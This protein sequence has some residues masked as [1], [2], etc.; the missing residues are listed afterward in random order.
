MNSHARILFSVAGYFNLA[1]GLIFLFAMPQLA[2]MIGMNPIPEDYVL[3]HFGS[4][5]V[6]VFGVG[7]LKVAADPVVNR[8]IIQLGILGKS[9][10]VLAGMVDWLLGNTNA[11]FPLLLTADV[12]FAVLFANYLRLHRA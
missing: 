1:V 12:V 10:V 7:Y 9:G 5:L 3:I 2:Q 4:V 8:P 6:I 11:A